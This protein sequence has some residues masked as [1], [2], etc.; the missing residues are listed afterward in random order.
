M[1]TASQ[2]SS[3]A[4]FIYGARG[5]A[6]V[7]AE[8]LRLN[9]YQIRGFIDEL[10]PTRVGEDFCGSTVLGGDE[11]LGDLIRSEVKN[12]VVAFGDNRQRVQ[13][14]D[15]LGCMGFRLVT[16][17]HPS[18]V[19]ASDAR[20]GPGT[21]V[22]AGAVVG[23]S[24]SIGSNAILNTQSS[25]DHDC[26]VGNGAHIGPGAIIS[27]VVE[28]GDCAWIGTGAVVSDHQRIGADA[29][30]GAG[31]VVVRD[32]P[33]AVVVMGVPARVSRAVKP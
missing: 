5:H 31:A 28:V 16:A 1:K 24:S 6:K 3:L 13:V 25:V 19:C 22:A 17:L 7:V 26:V 8:I 4:T 12:F 2:V 30:V 23:P 27:G 10:Q 11:V 15:R 9:G 32:V 18:A 20:I 33:D 14:A 21:V 29:I